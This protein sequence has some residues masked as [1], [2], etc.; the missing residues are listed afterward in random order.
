MFT[1]NSFNRE[2]RHTEYYEIGETF[3]IYDA[4]DEKVAEYK[5]KFPDATSFIVG[6][7]LAIPV[8]PKNT[9]EIINSKG[10]VIKTLY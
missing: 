5:E 3:S 8:L 9:Y 6:K 4:S 1:I 7:T 10:T 2:D